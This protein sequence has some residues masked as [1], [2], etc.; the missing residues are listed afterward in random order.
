MKGRGFFISIF[1]FAVLSVFLAIRRLWW[2]KK[3][4]MVK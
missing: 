3:E 2:K 1:V 4:T